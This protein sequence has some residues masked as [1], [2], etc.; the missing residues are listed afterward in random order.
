MNWFPDMFWL[1]LEWWLWPLLGT[2]L[3]LAIGWLVWR[4]GW[5]RSEVENNER[6]RT[7]RRASGDLDTELRRTRLDVDAH[8]ERQVALEA[9]FASM[10]TDRDDALARLADHESELESVIDVRSDLEKGLAEKESEVSSLRSERESS[11]QS[12]HGITAEVE[13]LRQQSSLLELDVNGAR[14]RVTEMEALIVKR[15]ARVASLEATVG[16]R[17][18][19]LASFETAVAERDM[20]LGDAETTIAH[21]SMQVAE[22]ESS[23]AASSSEVI[24]L[25]GFVSERDGRIVELD[26]SV[27]ERDGRVA[28]LEHLVGERDGRVAELDGDVS[29][30]I[31]RMVR[32]QTLVGERDGRVAELEGLLG[33][34]D[35]RTRENESLLREREQTAGERSDKIAVLEATLEQ[36]D[37]ALVVAEEQ[38]ASDRHRT[39]ELELQVQQQLTSEPT[40]ERAPGVDAFEDQLQ[41]LAAGR[42]ADYIDDLQEVSGVGPVMEEMLNGQGL[43]TFYQLALLDHAGVEALESR[44]EAFPGRIVRDDWVPQAADLHL[45]HHGEDL[46]GRVVVERSGVRRELQASGSADFLDANIA[47]SNIERPD[48]GSDDLTPLKGIGDKMSKTLAENGVTTFYQLARL[49]HAAVDDLETRTNLQ[50][51]QIR[52]ENWVPQAAQLHFEAH[53]DD[54]YELVTVEGN[55]VDAFEQQLAA[56]SRGRRLDYVDELQLI[57]GVGPKMESLLHANG[58]KTFIQVSLLNEEGVEALNDRLEFFPGRIERDGWVAQAARLHRKHH[59]GIS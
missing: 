20:Q 24:E 30:R 46:H 55:Y 16:E 8:A 47:R 18:A 22:L 41:S 37:A 33:E 56:A 59:P 48:A 52:R 5:R 50:P 35:V 14:D 58:L 36:R 9:E 1:F 21:A 34:R 54:I 10:A 45:T 40:V 27:S 7:L 13:G 44:I 43:N 26:A 32:L 19:W 25:R 3:G 4:R 49:D 17:D 39:A 11:V 31:G 28:E 23:A 42:S 12:L 53:G 29:E 2:L 51:G 57:N 6:V 15:D 38:A